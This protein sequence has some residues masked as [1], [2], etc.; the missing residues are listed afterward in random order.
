MGKLFLFFGMALFVTMSYCQV[1][2]GTTTPSPAAM[3]EVSSTSDGGLTYRGFMPPRVPDV[4]AR[5]LINPSF[6]DAGLLIYLSSSGC[7][8]FW[9]GLIWENIKCATD[10]S[11]PPTLLGTQNFEIVPVIPE[12]P[13]TGINT[14]N[15]FIDSG[16]FPEGLPNYNSEVRG[17]GINSGTT[18]LTF[19]PLDASLFSFLIIRF[20]LA[21]FSKSS[22]QGADSNDSVIL[23]V[24]NNGVNYIEEIKIL[25][26]NNSRWGFNN[27]NLAIANSS[28]SGN[29]TIV[30]STGNFDSG[31]GKVELKNIP[32]SANFSFK[33]HLKNDL[34]DEIWI[35]DDVEVLGL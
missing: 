18:E 13:V 30:Q 4:A 35:I 29:P 32:T 10:I 28:G 33:I 31:I 8:Q 24:S 15:Y 17:Y 14:S 3:L 6:S 12:L 7:L 34:N 16:P 25:G 11:T 23:S 21:S 9:T 2:I 1:G 20:H 26:Y 27:N 19:G 22:N 5:N